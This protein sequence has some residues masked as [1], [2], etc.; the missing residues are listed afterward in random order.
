LEVAVKELDRCD[1]KYASLLGGK[2]LEKL[3]LELELPEV[4]S[5][6]GGIPGEK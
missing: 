4:S 1:F 6:N 3:Q 5:R 2:Q